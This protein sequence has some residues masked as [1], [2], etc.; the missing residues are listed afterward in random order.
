[1]TIAGAAARRVAVYERVSSADQR[2]RETIKTQTDALDARLAAEPGIELVA[3]FADDGWSG[4]KPLA[5]RPGGRALLAAAESHRF[6]ELWLYRLDR[7]G[8]NLADTAANGRRLEGLGVTVVTLQ[9]G[10]LTPFMFDLFAMLAQNEHRVFHE[11]SADG[12]ARAAR[13]GRYTGGIVAYGYR[14]EGLKQLARLVP[15]ETSVGG[16]LTAAGVIRH[17]YDRL[18]LGQASCGEVAD[19]LNALGVYTHYARDGRGIRGQR[20]RARWTAGRVRNMVINPIYAGDLQYGRR[21]AKRDRA[22]ISASIEAL[23]APALW[24]ATQDTLARNRRVVK[25]STRAYLLRGV[26]HCSECLLTYVGSQ[27]QKGV[28]WYRCGGRNRDRGPLLGRCTGPT[29]RTDAL[30][31][32]IWSDI[33]RFLRDPGD[34]LDEL[35]QERDGGSAVAEA[36]AILLRRSLA[37][38][39]DE[40]R[41]AINLVVKGTLPEAALQPEIDR[42]A[43]ERSHLQARLAAVAAPGAPELPD[44]AI[45]LL[46]EVRARLDARLSIEAQQEIVRLLVGR[47]SIHA[48]PAS[49]GKRSVRAVVEYRFPAALH[50]DTGTGSSPR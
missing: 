47:I 17:V 46:S 32:V 8:R 30:D 15:D 44:A 20:T 24:Q 31:P 5:D 21:T 36:E 12:M 29:V 3:R 11:R 14:V 9:E 33:E 25:N 50:I 2:E 7:L 41:R 22:V 18:G 28:G 43:A 37:R 39:D 23:V 38:L 4:M 35:A 42:I 13:E 26:I 40:H 19:E 6:D 1:M 34:I 16:E 27:G 45:D 10:R 48:T 49:E